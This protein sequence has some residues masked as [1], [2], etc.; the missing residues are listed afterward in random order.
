M[1]VGSSRLPWYADI[2]N[3]IVTTTFAIDS[4]RAEKEKIR[5]QSKY[6]VWY[7]PHLWK[8]YGDQI[9]R[10]SVDDSEIHSIL[11]FCHSSESG[12]HF[13]RKRTA[14]KI[15]ECGFY[16]PTIYRDAYNF[17]KRCE[18]CQKTGNLSRRNQ[19]PLYN[20]YICEI[21]DVWGIDFM[22]PFPPSFGYTYILM[23]VDYVFK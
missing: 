1:Y 14:H 10:R 6:Y 17:C 5:A 18:A 15:L 23:L 8:C 7:K 3:Y 16:W 21:F 22:G 19:M 2:A 4:S 9:I 20:V 11:T 13:G 12:G